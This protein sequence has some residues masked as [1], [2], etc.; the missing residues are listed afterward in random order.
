MT[1][2]VPTGDQGLSSAAKAGIGAG[3]GVGGAGIVCVLG[4]ILYLRKLYNISRSKEI[5]ELDS[6]TRYEMQ[7]TANTPEL[8]SGGHIGG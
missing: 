4:Y 7:T 1:A 5:A 6:G 3:V 2:S 8:E